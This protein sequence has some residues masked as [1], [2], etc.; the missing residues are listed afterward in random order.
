MKAIGPRGP[1]RTPA[2]L[3][4]IVD[5]GMKFL[6]SRKEGVKASELKRFGTLRPSPK[7]FLERFGH[8][9]KV[10]MN[11]KQYVYFG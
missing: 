5:E 10:E 1:K 9:P 4:K 7:V 2:E 6:K 3:Q 11:G 8:Q